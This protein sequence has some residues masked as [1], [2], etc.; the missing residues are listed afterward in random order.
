LLAASLD[1]KLSL[2]LR[3]SASS[4]RTSASCELV[5]HRAELAAL[6]G[7]V[8]LEVAER[9]AQLLQA[10]LVGVVPLR[11]LLGLAIEPV[12]LGLDVLDRWLRV[13]GGRGDHPDTG[14]DCCRSESAD[15]PLPTVLH[16]RALS[17]CLS[18]AYRVS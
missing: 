1:W 9:L 14:E 13:R 3:S 5:A 15:Q 12:D 10:G 18:Y 2:S 6:A 7:L 4:L 17:L 8:G 16:E 11:G